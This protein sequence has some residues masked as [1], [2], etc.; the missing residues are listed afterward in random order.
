MRVIL[1]L[2]LSACGVR[3]AAW[4]GARDDALCRLRADCWGLDA[5]RDACREA[6]AAE[7]EPPCPDYDGDHALACLDGLDAQ[8]DACPEVDA[9]TP[10]ADCWLVCERPG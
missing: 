10:P 4:P 1:L 8:A 7:A 9:W 2:S 3:E 6:L 5:S